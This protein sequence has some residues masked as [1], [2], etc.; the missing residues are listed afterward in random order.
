MNTET[1]MKIDHIIHG[2]KPLNELGIDKSK[3]YVKIVGYDE[4][5]HWAHR[6]SFPIQIFKDV[7]P[8]GEKNIDASILIPWRYIA[9]I[10]HFPDEEGFDFPDPFTTNLGFKIDNE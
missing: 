1:P 7:K 10:V 6:R 8:A 5:G 3:V 2:H 9:S 4:Y